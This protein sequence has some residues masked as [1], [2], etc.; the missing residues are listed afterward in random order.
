MV[1]SNLAVADG[2]RERRARQTRRALFECAMRLFAERGFENTTVEQITEAA[3]VAKGTFFNYFPNKES[4]LLALIERQ[5]EI[6]AAAVQQASDAHSVRPILLQMARA[7]SASTQGSS[8]LIRSLLG[9]VLADDQLASLFGPN[10]E[11]GQQALAL[12][13]K[14]GQELGEFRTGLSALGL[15][16]LFQQLMFGTHMIWA[17]APRPALPRRL[18]ESL[19]FFMLGAQPRTAEEKRGGK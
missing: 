12:I 17:L 2:R 3:D 1:I 16:R 15:A 19:D 14:R 7:L 8:A 5:R 13:M 11:A 9:R 4:I 6:I 18:D 10:L